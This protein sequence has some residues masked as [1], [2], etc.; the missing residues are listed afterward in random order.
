M[1]H[2]PHFPWQEGPQ[3][4]GIQHP[5]PS[6]DRTTLTPLISSPLKSTFPALSLFDF[7][8]VLKGAEQSL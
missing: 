6:S 5:T 1:S 3:H 4:A 8:S 2:E 7:L